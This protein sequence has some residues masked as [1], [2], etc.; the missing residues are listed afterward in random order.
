VERHR[1]PL[2]ERVSQLWQLPTTIA[3]A[4]TAGPGDPSP[5]SALVVLAD[6]IA[7]A[8]E[9]GASAH[10]LAVELRL[11]PALEAQIEKFVSH[12]PGAIEAFIQAPDAP[13]KRAANAVAKPT[14]VLKGELRVFLAPI[15]DL[16]KA[17]APE[18]LES[19]GLTPL[20]LVIASRRPLQE[21]S[22]IRLGIQLQPSIE[23]WF[24]VLL[25]A[26]E[27]QRFRIELLAFAPSSELRDRMNKLWSEAQP[28]PE[29]LSVPV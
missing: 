12:L 16:R 27:G 6:A 4:V 24:N 29:R 17:P 9:R 21:S 20:G 14:S 13:R 7:A 28:I 22:V 19:V 3:A 1:A 23:A 5:A 11:E 2:A 25:C 8:L 26:P 10:E 18:P 15:I